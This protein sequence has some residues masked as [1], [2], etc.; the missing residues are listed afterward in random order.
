[1]VLGGKRKRAEGH[2]KGNQIEQVQRFKYLGSMSEE[3]QRC[4]REVNTMIAMA[5]ESFM[6]RRR[7]LCG[8]LA[9][10]VRKIVY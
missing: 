5:K 7:L 2:L 3:D 1:M 8:T 6:K 10:E 4:T 9:K